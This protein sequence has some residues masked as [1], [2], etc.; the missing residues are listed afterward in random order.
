VPIETK[1]DDTGV[2]I[3]VVCGLLLTIVVAFVCHH[4]GKKSGV[5]GESGMDKKQEHSSVS[6]L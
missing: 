6:A 2:I 3:S 1:T 4:Q 5:V